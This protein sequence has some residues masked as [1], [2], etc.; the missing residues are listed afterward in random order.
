M[1][2][3]YLV[4]A[5]LVFIS[6]ISNFRSTPLFSLHSGVILLFAIA[7]LIFATNAENMSNDKPNMTLSFAGRA[8]ASLAGFIE[9]YFVF[10]KS[11]ASAVIACAVCYAFSTWYK[12][13]GEFDDKMDQKK[14]GYE[15]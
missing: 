15:R 2:N 6:V 8:I 11:I 1:A 3:R 9:F 13:I 14:L 12:N 10:Q 5:V 4:T 7:S